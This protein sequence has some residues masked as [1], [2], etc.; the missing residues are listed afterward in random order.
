VAAKAPLIDPQV[1]DS[2]Y[3]AA[4]GA[5]ATTTILNVELTARCA[6]QGTCLTWI[7]GGTGASHAQLYAYTVPTN[8][9]LDYLGYKLKQRSRFWM[10]PQ[11]IFTS[12]NLFS[13]GRSYG[14][15]Q[16]DLVGNKSRTS[17]GLASRHIGF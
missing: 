15:L 13:A 4:T 10:V 17:N 14:R 16:L 2:S 8:I 12:A 1:A 5:L 3:W 7:S 11:M 9:A 6:Q